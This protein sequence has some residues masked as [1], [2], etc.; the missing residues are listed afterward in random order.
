MVMGDAIKSLDGVSAVWQIA[1][2]GHKMMDCKFD[3]DVVFSHSK[4]SVAIDRQMGS[5]YLYNVISG[6]PKDYIKNVSQKAADKL[7][8]QLQSYGAKKIVCVLDENS[9]DD[10]RWHTGHE[11]QQEN[12]LCHCLTWALQIVLYYSLDHSP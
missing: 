6:Y 9:L 5:K 1:F 8:K 10:S 4:F 12:Y 2:D 11:M 3:V 7:R